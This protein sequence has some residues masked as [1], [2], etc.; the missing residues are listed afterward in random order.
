MCQA[1]SLADGHVDRAD[2]LMAYRTRVLSYDIRRPP[3]NGTPT[4]PLPNYILSE[5]TDR[6][7]CSIVKLPLVMEILITFTIRLFLTQIACKIT[8][9]GHNDTN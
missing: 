5:T 9:R 2:V 8:H 7:S 6:V 3:T 1:A 4:L